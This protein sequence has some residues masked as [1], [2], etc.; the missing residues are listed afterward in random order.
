LPELELV[1]EEDEKDIRVREAATEVRRVGE[2][3]YI[4]ETIEAED[5]SGESDEDEMPER[6]EANEAATDAEE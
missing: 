5:E 6:L 2:L 4:E 3:E 1:E